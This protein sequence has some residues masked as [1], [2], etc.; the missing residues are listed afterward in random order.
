MRMFSRP[1]HKTNRRP[2]RFLALFAVAFAAFAMTLAA[3][4]GDDDD[5]TTPATATTTSAS[6][7]PAASP[8]AAAFPFTFTDST[9]TSITMTEA[10]KRVISY[11]PGATEVLFA[12]GAGP[13]VI[14]TDEFSNY[15]AEAKALPHVQY[16]KPS[17]EP[18]LAMKP[19]LVIMSGRQEGQAAQFRALGMKVALFQEPKDV[20]AVFDQIRTIGKVTGHGPDADRL[21]VSLEQRLEKV[22][23]SV[24]TKTDA[25]LVFYE[26]TP[27]LFTVS[28]NSFVGNLLTIAKAKNIVQ[29][30]ANAFPQISAETVLKADPA[31]ILLADGG[32]SGGQSIETVRARPGWSTLKAVRD[33]KVIVVN[34][35]TFSRPGPRVI[36]A[37]EQ[38]VGLLY[39]VR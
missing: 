29:D 8:A 5:D 34:A 16:S 4:G 17:P 3:C 36:D 32:D 1:L 18:A 28:P 27:D 35:D 2:W 38:L 7:S 15:P 26:I 20:P 33:G 22:K 19:D 25:P 9:N 37:L 31:L 6:G 10:P 13:Q 14:A 12:V 23:A 24:A 11:S 39:P 21:A 30:T